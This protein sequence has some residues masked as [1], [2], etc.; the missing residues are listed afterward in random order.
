MSHMVGRHKVED[1]A[2]W[3]AVYDEHDATRKAMGGRGHLLLRNADSPDELLVLE[4]W[5]NLNR[6]KEFA[7]SQE[8]RE[9]MA[10]AGVTD[11]P[12][13]Y[14]CETLEHEPS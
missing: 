1:Y 9:A 7:G 12:D 11:A 8:L 13:I 4:D 2:K 5:D 3:K 14:F 6:A 10:R